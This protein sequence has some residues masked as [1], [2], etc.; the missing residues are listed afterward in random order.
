MYKAVFATCNIVE[1]LTSYYGQSWE[2]CI[3]DAHVIACSTARSY[4][5]MCLHDD[6]YMEEN[7]TTQIHTVVRWKGW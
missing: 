2:A 3:I 1:T 5:E 4:V 6:S 7:A